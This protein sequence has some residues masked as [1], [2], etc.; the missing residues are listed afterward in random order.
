M[1]TSK[2][3]LSVLGKWRRSHKGLACASVH[4]GTWGYGHRAEVCAVTLWL[5]SCLS[6]AR[7]YRSLHS[8]S[9]S[10]H[11]SGFTLGEFWRDDAPEVP[12]TAERSCS[13]AGGRIIRET[14]VKE[15]TYTW[16]THKR[17][18]FEFKTCQWENFSFSLLPRSFPL[19]GPCSQ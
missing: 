15:S 12:C 11:Q 5:S 14:R 2:L 16:Y 10:Q 3:W 19:P 1:P 4:S 18:N 17:H 9:K 13:V 7:C 6:Q 8:V